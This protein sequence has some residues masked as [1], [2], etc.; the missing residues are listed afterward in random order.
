MPEGNYSYLDFPTVLANAINNQIIGPSG[1]IRFSVS[2]NPNTHFTTISNSTYTF[3]MEIVTYY[4]KRLGVYCD[5]KNYDFTFKIGANDPKKTEDPMPEQAYNSL[6]YLMGYRKLEYLNQMSYTSESVYESE[7]YKYVYFLVNDYVGN[8]TKNTIGVFPQLMLDED[9]LALIPISSLQFST[10]FTDGS[11]YIYRTR[12]YNGPV[13]INKILIQLIN[14]MGQLADIHDT[15]FAF[16]LQIETIADMT[17]K[18][19]YKSAQ[20]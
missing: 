1:P 19:M 3:S 7:R 2:I 18:F 10:T 11:T 9:I 8:Q 13:D 14:P 16:C 12:N 5:D 15:D 6:G 17:K 4:P 20:I